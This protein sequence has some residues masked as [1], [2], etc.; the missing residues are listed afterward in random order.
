MAPLAASLI[1]VTALLLS[2]A[3]AENKGQHQQ[4]V[5]K[6]GVN[7]DRFDIPADVLTLDDGYEEFDPQKFAEFITRENGQST[8]VSSISLILLSFVIGCAL[9]VEICLRARPIPQHLQFGR[10]LDYSS[11]CH[12]WR[13]RTG[14]LLQ[15]GRT[16]L[17][18]VGSIQ[19]L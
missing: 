7:D 8:F 2:L 1:A 13:F 10:Q 15:T 11:E 5:I 3:S 18:S 4:K 12:L 17:Q 19:L 14:E 9:F 16:R 6:K